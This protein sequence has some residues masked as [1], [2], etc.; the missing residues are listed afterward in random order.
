MSVPLCGTEVRNERMHTSKQRVTTHLI[1]LNGQT[2]KQADGKSKAGSS[3]GQLP[4]VTPEGAA[5]T[6]VS[7]SAN[8]QPQRYFKQLVCL[9]CLQQAYSTLS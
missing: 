4:Q 8:A 7:A 9:L 6:D 3:R 1:S 2:E 5:C